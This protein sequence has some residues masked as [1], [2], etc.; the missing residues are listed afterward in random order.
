[1]Q[2]L[3]MLSVLTLVMTFSLNA[4]KNFIRV[5]VGDFGEVKLSV[6]DE[7]DNGNILHK[8]IKNFDDENLEYD[9]NIRILT[10]KA[11]ANAQQASMQEPYSLV[12][13]GAMQLYLA[14]KYAGADLDAFYDFNDQLKNLLLEK[15]N[16]GKTPIDLLKESSNELL[17]QIA[18]EMNEQEILLDIEKRQQVIEQQRK[19]I[20]K[21]LKKVIFAMNVAAG[22]TNS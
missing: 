10:G 22:T 21:E 1:M 13:E 2:N 17:S 4:S 15:D 7:S 14:H 3:K 5:P 18:A 6:N 11:Y 16:D 8:F 20:K 9:I 19:R 12:E